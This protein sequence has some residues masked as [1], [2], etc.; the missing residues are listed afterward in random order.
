[1]FFYSIQLKR[2]IYGLF[3]FGLVL[4]GLAFLYKEIYRPTHTFKNVKADLVI[5]KENTLLKRPQLLSQ[6]EERNK[7][8]DENAQKID[9]VAL[10][11]EKGS[12]KTV[13]ARYYGYSQHDRTVW[14]FNAENKETLARSFRDFAYSLAETKSEK[15]ELLQIET[16]ESPEI[17]DLSLLSFVRKILKE[18]KNWLLIYDNITNFPEIENYFPLDTTLWG[19]G[20]VILVTRDENI[21]NTSYIKPEY[22]IKVGELQKEDALIL[23]TSILF[24]FFPQELDIE[25]KEEALR[26]L[27]QIPHFP[28]DV[29]IAARYIKNGNISY[30]KYLDLLNQKDLA[31]EKLQ[32]MIVVE[33][34]D[35]LK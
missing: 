18:Q 25:K 9:V 4:S 28:L 6:I 27:N 15:Q 7:T 3:C 21:K 30:E 22:I 8:H 34:S 17:K 10:V 19:V 2:R 12:G 13:L 24:D 1:M 31:F 29:S 16:I 26:F 35:Y 5:P 14:E 23:F 33:A 11:G 32:N 20:K